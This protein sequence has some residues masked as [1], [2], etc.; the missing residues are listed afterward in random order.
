[1]AAVAPAKVELPFAYSALVHFSSS[2][3]VDKA[4]LGR[5]EGRDKRTLKDGVNSGEVGADGHDDHGEG[6]GE[7][8]DYDISGGIVRRRGPGLKWGGGFQA[9]QVDMSY[10]GTAGLMS[11]C[12]PAAVAG[13]AP[14]GSSWSRMVFSVEMILRLVIL[15]DAWGIE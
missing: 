10:V 15:T 13:L 12:W 7:K 4:P 5:G 2:L 6:E 8:L 14:T 1:M 9:V 11:D 3:Q